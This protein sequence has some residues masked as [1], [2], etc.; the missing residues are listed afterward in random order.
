MRKDLYGLSLT[1]SLV[2]AGAAF[3]Q[4]QSYAPDDLMGKIKATGE[5]VITV[6]SSPIWTTLDAA[7]KPSGIIPD[8]LQAFLDKE[9]IDAKLTPV[10]M[11]FDSIIPALTSGKAD[12]GANTMYVTPARQEQILF[13]RIMLYNSEGLFVAKGNPLNLK[14]LADLC[15]HSG[16]TYKGTS[17]VALLEKASKECPDGTEID[18][19]QYATLDL[20][21][22]DVAAGRLDGGLVDRSAGQ[23]ALIRNPN[24]PFEI[25]PDYVT[26]SRAANGGALPIA[27]QYKDFVTAF[28][29]TYT[30]LLEEGVIHDI[31]V[32]YGLEPTDVYLK[33]E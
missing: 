29:A 28:N 11:P 2:F 31:L 16:G 20:V 32:K 10:A 27:P 17:Y 23:Y 25:S 22:G 30:Q 1:A 5:M 7:G 21:L 4:T 13:S 3:A 15:G 9:G 18:I 14:S 19:K 24:L 8:I 26:P 33:P 6:G 12:V